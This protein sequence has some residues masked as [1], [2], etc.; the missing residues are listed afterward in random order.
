MEA[1][2]QRRKEEYID[3]AV[4]KKLIHIRQQILT[5]YTTR[6]LEYFELGQPE[7]VPEH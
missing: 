2:A 1:F 4:K 3:E 6:G 7:N 5:V